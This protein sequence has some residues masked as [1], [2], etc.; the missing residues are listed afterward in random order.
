[1]PLTALRIPSY[2]K[3]GLE[4]EQEEPK[5]R[6]ELVEAGAQRRLPPGPGAESQ[7]EVSE[8][9]CDSQGDPSAA[10]NTEGGIADADQQSGKEQIPPTDDCGDWKPVQRGMAFLPAPGNRRQ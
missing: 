1:M 10:Q 2:R 4:N 6:R 5:E 9:L 3:E 8:G 7:P